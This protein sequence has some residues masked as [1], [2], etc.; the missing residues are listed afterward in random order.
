[1]T[2]R[3]LT[4]E[5]RWRGERIWFGRVVQWGQLAPYAYRC[6]R[7]ETIGIRHMKLNAGHYIT[8]DLWRLG[9]YLNWFRIA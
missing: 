3:L 5:E 8:F 7:G 9:W 1:M 4:P 2:D 6:E